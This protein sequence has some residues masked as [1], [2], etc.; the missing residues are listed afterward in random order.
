MLQA[1]FTFYLEPY[2]NLY[3][4]LDDLS[5]CYEATTWAKTQP[6]LK[7]A[8]R[9]CSRGDWMLWLAEEAGIDHKTLT[10]AAVDYAETAYEYVTNQDSLT[11]IMLCNHIT[12]EYCA[13]RASVEDVIEGGKCAWK[14]SNLFWETYNVVPAAK[15]AS[16]AVRRAAEGLRTPYVFHI[17]KLAVLV[18]KRIPYAM[19]SKALNVK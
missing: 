11:A 15:F 14:V 1:S 8:W 5:A 7:S 10:L 13:G 9:S 17:R 4:K 19:I 3:K 18:R 6:N 2:M 12:R 16:Y